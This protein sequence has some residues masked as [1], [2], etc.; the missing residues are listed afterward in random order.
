MFDDE[1][2][3]QWIQIQFNKKTVKELSSEIGISV[4]AL[5][6]V[7]RTGKINTINFLKILNAFKS[8]SDNFM[9]EKE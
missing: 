3:L 5:S 9:K 6:R 8:S 2:L 7:K 1:K 4:S